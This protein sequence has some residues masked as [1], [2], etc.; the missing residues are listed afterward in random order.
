LVVE[1]LSRLKGSKLES[2]EGKEMRQEAMDRRKLRRCYS[3]SHCSGDETRIEP[4]QTLFVNAA[5]MGDAG[6]TQ[7]PWFFDI[8]LEPYLKVPTI[9]A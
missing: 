5:V 8:E 2:V 9:M 4:G 6:P 1:S 3:I 7:L